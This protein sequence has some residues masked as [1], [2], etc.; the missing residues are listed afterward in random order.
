MGHL[1]PSLIDCFPHLLLTDYLCIRLSS[2]Y[3]LLPHLHNTLYTKTLCS[4]ICISDLPTSRISTSYSSLSNIPLFLILSTSA[5]SPATYVHGPNIPLLPASLSPSSYINFSI[6][7]LFPAS[8][9]RF[10]PVLRRKHHMILTIP[11]RV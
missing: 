2:S 4:C 10:P 5:V 6:S 3:L 8:I 1:I 11:T 9:K 7:L